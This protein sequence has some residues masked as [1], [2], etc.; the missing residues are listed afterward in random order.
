MKKQLF[1][2]TL[3][4][5]LVLVAC[6]KNQRTVKK[7]EGNWEEIS[8]NGNAIAEGD[9]GTLNFQYCKLK[10]DEWCQMSYT[11]S[12][13]YNA[14]AFDYQVREKGEVLVERIQDSTKGAIELQGKIVELTE[15]DLT[16]ELS[17]FGFITTTVYKKK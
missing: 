12:D 14:G 13:G 8:I 4:L 5:S 16:L 7:L 9:R 11:D 10:K 6:N 3:L 15:S 17:Y 2:L 1:Y